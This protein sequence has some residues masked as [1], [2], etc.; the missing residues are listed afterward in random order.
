MDSLN[1]TTLQSLPSLNLIPCIRLMYTL[2]A[3]PDNY[4]VIYKMTYQ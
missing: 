1:Y 2:I 3:K 4:Q